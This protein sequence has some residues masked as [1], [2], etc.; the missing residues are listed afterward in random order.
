MAENATPAKI[1]ATR[2]Y[3]AEVVLHGSI[4]DDA[5]AKARELVASEGLTYVHP[6]NDVDL[7]SGQGTVGL[8][9]VEDWPEVEVVVVPIG[10]GG[11]ISGV[12]AA[13]K[14]E[15]PEVRIVGVESSDGPAMKTS[16]EAGE[17]VT[18]E[19]CDTIIDG[20]RVKRVGEL[21]F[22]L[23]QRFVDEIVA[24][25]DAT[26]FENVLWTMA[27]TKLVVEGA[28]AAPVAALRMGLVDAPPGTKVVCVLSGGNI[29]LSQLRGLRWN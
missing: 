3:G 14:Q 19:R 27:H 20:L 12:S 23:V 15:R 24:V 29:D 13:V 18:L 26:I 7:I 28:A 25:P 2:G 11:L 5:D 10:G 17:L 16:V 22:D 4:W 9:I 21:T 6:F 8:E 1:A